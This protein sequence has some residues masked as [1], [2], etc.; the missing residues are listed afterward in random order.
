MSGAHETGLPY[1]SQALALLSASVSPFLLWE[2]NIVCLQQD[3][4]DG[5]CL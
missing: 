2:G 4:G 3:L 5:S 1:L